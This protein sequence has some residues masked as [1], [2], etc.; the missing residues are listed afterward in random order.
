MDELDR[1]VYQLDN[2]QMFVYVD[3]HIHRELKKRKQ[4]IGYRND[5][6][7]ARIMCLINLIRISRKLK[8]EFL[9]Y[10]D[11]SYDGARFGRKSKEE[12]VQ[13]MSNDHI[14]DYLPNFKKNI[15]YF[16]SEKK[17]IKGAI[18]EWKILLF[19]GENKKNVIKQ[20]KKIIEKFFIKTKFKSRNLSVKLNKYSLEYNNF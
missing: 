17:I 14:F 15:R 4:L 5:A 8:K 9:F 3:N 6:A 19:K 20:M 1:F 7:G 11:T 10:W 18:I 13:M 12:I 2:H 16:D